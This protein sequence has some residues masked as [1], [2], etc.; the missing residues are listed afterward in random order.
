MDIEEHKKN[1]TSCFC[2]DLNIMDV[3]IALIKKDTKK[4]E[5]FEKYISECEVEKSKIITSLQNARTEKEIYSVIGNLKKPKM[6]E[7]L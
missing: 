3:L 5:D 4:L 7:T 1:V 6:K 2:P